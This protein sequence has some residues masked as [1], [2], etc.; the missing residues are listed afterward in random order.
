MLANLKVRT[1]LLAVIIPLVAVII[2]GAVYGVVDRLGTAN[3]YDDDADLIELA[4]AQAVFNSSVDTESIHAIIGSGGDE[5]AITKFEAAA[6]LSNENWELLR[7]A[8]QDIAERDELLDDRLSSL[9]DEFSRVVDLRTE[10]LAGTAHPDVVQVEYEDLNDALVGVAAAAANTTD[11]PE[12]LSALES[13]QKLS[14][15]AHATSDIAREAAATAA[16]QADGSVPELRERLGAYRQTSATFDSGADDDL[17]QRYEDSISEAEAVEIAVALEEDTVSKL[18][19]AGV[20]NGETLASVSAANASLQQSVLDDATRDLDNLGDDA[21]EMARNLAIISGIALLAALILSALFARSIARPMRQLNKRTASLASERIPNSVEQIQKSGEAEPLS[22]DVI[23]V[24]SKSELG[25]LAGS[26]NSIS[27]L[28]MSVARRQSE[29]VRTGIADIFVHLARRNQ[30]LLDR[31]IEFIDQLEANEQDPDQLD[32]LFRL[33]HLATRMRRNAESLLVMAGVETP[34]RRG[35]SIGL[36]D[37]LRVAAGEVEDFARIEL[38]SIDQVSVTG[39][40]AVDLAHLVSELMENATQFS[41]PDTK[42][43]VRAGLGEHGEFKITIADRGIGMCPEQCEAANELLAN[44]PLIGL[45]LSRSLGFTVVSRLAGRIDAVVSIVS[46]A[47]TGTVATVVIPI[48]AITPAKAAIPGATDQTPQPDPDR[49]PREPQFERE[50]AKTPTISAALAELEPM[51]D[52]TKPPTEPPAESVNGA[53][54]VPALPPKASRVAPETSADSQPTRQADEEPY[55]SAQMTPRPPS[56]TPSLPQEPAT[57]SPGFKELAQVAQA[58]DPILESA[59][60]RPAPSA[61]GLAR[62]VPGATSLDTEPSGPAMTPT[63]RSPEEVRRLLSRYRGGLDKGRAGT[64]P[65]N[66]D[67][68]GGRQQ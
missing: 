49:T 5:A 47:G 46:N 52:A 7:G 60:R 29:V 3:D 37:V 40:V 32:N 6:T 19:D 38:T 68:A 12:A 51:I 10:I 11:T 54:T 34:R 45:A 15:I 9:N 2:A 50:E 42:I 26:I 66:D 43:E 63:K 62:R 58:Q 28:T 24:E 8:A 39:A 1:K 33:D 20:G 21:R 61:D 27:A 30:A 41:P 64:T 35:T 59:S 22:P 56:R 16:D 13:S 48:A 31:Q 53:P 14:S 4:S 55:A 23:P 44:P 36:V 57:Q 65:E 25:Q 18:L 67:E 17:T